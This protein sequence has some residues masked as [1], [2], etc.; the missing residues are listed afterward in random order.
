M[1][2][3]DRIQAAVRELL[4]SI[5]EDVN[6][7]GLLETPRRVADMYVELFEGI[8]ADQIGRAHV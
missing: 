4:I 2:D 8:E 3:R 7:D 5:G 1:I 6:R